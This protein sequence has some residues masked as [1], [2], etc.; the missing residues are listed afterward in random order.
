MLETV[1]TRDPGAVEEAVRALHASLFP[2]ADRLFVARAF[3]WV[4]RCF[5]GEHPGWQRI[6]AAYHDFEHTLQ[7]ALCLSRLL[8]GRHRAGAVP[9]LTAHGF[10][11][12]L[13]A[14]LFHDTGYLKRRDDVAGTGAKYTAVHVGRSAAFAREFLVPLGYAEAD[15][16]AVQNMINCTGTGA[17]IAAIPFRSE[18][19]RTIGYALATADLLGQM[20]ARDYV[21]KLPVLYAEFAEAARHAIPGAPPVMAFASADA[22]VRNTP[23]FWERFVR[24][25]IDSEFR[26]LHAY[27]NDPY[28]DGPN[29]YLQRIERN[30]AA[31]R[32]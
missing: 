7:G 8:A 12:G 22:L 2:E 28:P 1:D 29:P 27:L 18:L 16:C 31:L 26:G 19:E 32:S 21:A 5:A 3:A 13:L 15:V 4:A 9:R 20:A 14:I 6:D 17:Q 10:E 30:L 25:K 24:P 11:L 23:N